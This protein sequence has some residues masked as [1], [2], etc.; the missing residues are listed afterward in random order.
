MGIW[1]KNYL[2]FIIL[3][4]SKVLQS[5]EGTFQC[6]EDILDDLK[7]TNFFRCNSLEGMP[8]DKG[9]LSFMELHED[10]LSQQQELYQQ[11]LLDRSIEIFI[12]NRM[13]VTRQL[14]TLCNVLTP[15][16]KK[17]LNPGN[18]LSACFKGVNFVAMNRYYNTKRA[19]NQEFCHKSDDEAKQIRNQNQINHIIDYTIYKAM[20]ANKKALIDNM[21]KQFL[22]IQEKID[23]R[24]IT[25]DKAGTLYE[26]VFLPEGS[27]ACLKSGSGKLIY[28]KLMNGL[29]VSQEKNKNCRT[30]FEKSFLKPFKNAVDNINNQISIF[31]TQHPT[32]F[33]PE[34]LPQDRYGMV[35]LKKSPYHQELDRLFQNDPDAK[36]IEN[37]IINDIAEK[38]KEFSFEKYAELREELD[39]SLSNVLDKTDSSY[40]SQLI[41]QDGQFSKQMKTICDTDGAF[42]PLYGD[43]HKDVFASYPRENGNAYFNDK[44]MLNYLHCRSRAL[45]LGE[46][47]NSYG[48]VAGG[49]LFAGGILLAIPSGGASLIFSSGILFAGGVVLT[50]DG[51][52]S[53]YKTKQQ[54]ETASGLYNMNRGSREDIIELSEQYDFEKTLIGVDVLLAFLN[55]NLFKNLIE[56]GAKVLD[57]NLGKLKFKPND[58]ADEGQ[59]RII[60]EL[61]NE[62]VKT[63]KMDELLKVFEKQSYKLTRVERKYFAGLADLLK[64]DPDFMRNG[65]PDIPKIKQRLDEIVNSCRRSN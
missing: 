46:A 12:D 43:L 23:Q 45:A 11:E 47:S 27:Y 10:I 18:E 14:P 42:L 1:A 13:D 3:I 64:K 4:Y 17:L 2:I 37:F 63:G 29:D 6:S 22:A 26:G 20:H 5:F 15:D 35:N 49:V 53:T 60:D 8:L 24:D 56:K 21:K 48:L 44:E 33:S 57:S 65:K 52:Y 39:Q 32:L 61:D 50:G 62:L 19:D 25:Q 9:K 40:R 31:E 38:G 36:K 7:Q 58:R 51:I 28:K 41:I 30:F 34:E 59:R 55:I 16:V 54:L